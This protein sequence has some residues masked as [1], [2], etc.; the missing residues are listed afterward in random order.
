MDSI[1]VKPDARVFS[2]MIWGVVVQVLPTTGWKRSQS[3]WLHRSLHGICIHPTIHIIINESQS[4]H[5]LTCKTGKNTNF[6]RV[7]HFAREHVLW[8]IC[9]VDRSLHPYLTIDT[10]HDIRLIA[11]CNSIP[12][13][14][15]PRLVF[16]S[17]V[18]TAL[19]VCAGKW[20]LCSCNSPT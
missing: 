2:S 1:V 12:V 15:I 19:L 8:I 11:E 14:I 13:M 10:Q 3:G 17:E 7:S 4:T 16:S 20:L 18:N 9:R 5:S 6:R